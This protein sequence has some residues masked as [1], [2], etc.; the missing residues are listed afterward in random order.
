MTTPAQP[1]RAT[2]AILGGGITGLTAAFR[3][4]SRGYSVRLFEQTR[5]LGGSVGSECTEGWLVERGPNS[6]LESEPALAEI[7]QSLG[8]QDQLITSLP[9]AKKR[10]IVRRGQLCDLPM[11]PGGFF[12]TP[13]FSFCG[14][15]RLFGDLFRRPRTRP[16][17]ISLGE[18]IRQ[19]FGQEA[20]DYGLNPFV[21]GVYAG[22]PG[23]LSAQYAFPKLWAMEQSHGS[24]LRGMG[25]A[26]KARRAANG[27]QR[28]PRPRL[29]SFARGLQT[30]V[31]ALAA[32]LPEGSVQLGARVE[33]VWSGP[34]WQVRWHD[35]QTSHTE[36]F[37]KV[38]CALPSGGLSQLAVRADGAKPLAGLAQLENPPVSSLFLGFRREQVRHP[39][40]G[41]GALIP[42]LERRPELGILFSS[43]LFADRAPEGHVAITVMVGGVRQPV[44]ARQSTDELLATVTPSLRDLLGVS[45]APVFVRHNFWPA[46]IPQYNL[47]Y[48]R[49]LAAIEACERAHPG[50]FIGGNTRDGISVP[51]CLRAGINLAGKADSPS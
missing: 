31:D 5:R 42:A 47:G 18:F 20:V 1:A 44:L 36:V 26:A 50:L 38:L 33:A 2:I 37:D 21:S 25:A 16:S 9:T 32:R 51:Q 8:L 13:L 24:I 23:K 14:K 10:F 29:I 7:V 28:P 27:G 34:R 4:V 48:G 49:H 19:H 3:L 43:S 12:K 11:S 40:D 17:D 22:D 15:L 35:G 6:L 30:L 41:F 45:G 46:A 39:L